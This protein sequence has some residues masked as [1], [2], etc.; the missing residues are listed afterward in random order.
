MKNYTYTVHVE[1][2][3]EGGY[4]ATVPALPGCHTQGETWEEA[5]SMAREAIQG[6]IEA[7]V[8]AGEPVPEEGQS[9]TSH[10]TVEAPSP[11]IA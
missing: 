9:I 3:Q 11:V 8:S 1:P 7:L 6:F 10:L 4:V 2:A 5:M